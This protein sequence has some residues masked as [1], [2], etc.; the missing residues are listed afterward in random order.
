MRRFFKKVV[1]LSLV[2]AMGAT[3]VACGGGEDTATTEATTAAETDGDVDTDAETG[4]DAAASEEITGE[5]TVLTNRTDL[6]DTKFA[7][8]KAAFEAKYPGTT[9]NFEPITDYEGDVAIRMQTTEYGDVLLIPNSVKSTDFATYFEPLGTVDEL[10]SKYSEQFLYAKQSEG[11]VYGLAQYANA[12]GVVYNKKVFETAGITELPKTPEE[13]IECLKTIKEKCPDV[14]PYYTNYKDGWTLTQWQD[15]AWGS[16]TGDAEYHNNG[17]VNEENPFSEGTSNYIVHKLM[18]DVVK[19]GLC[20]EDP[21]TTDWESSKG[22]INRGEI[23]CMVLG[24]WAVSQCQA[25][26]ANSGDIGYMPFP[27]TVDGKQYATAGADYC[28]A[29]NKNSE[30]KA[31][32]RAWIDYILDES[33]YAQSEG[34]ISIK[35]D[36]P[37]PDTLADFSNVELVVDAAATSENEGKFDK[38]SEESDINLYADTQKKRIVEA[39]MGSTNESFDD[40]MND[41]N[42]WWAEA[43]SNYSAE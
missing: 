14:I 39:A 5:I 29:I 41:W 35:K 13:F 11:N 7:E 31:T 34:C 32:A 23:A 42:T 30:N 21:T 25:A 33:G 26:D 17:M 38:L 20:E 37:L 2:A 3:L 8:Y 24:S 4:D 43:L 36:D 19:E 6:V 9:V 10:S 16:V 27:V 28:Y 22:M 15:H 18:Y 1:S 40:I 12:Q